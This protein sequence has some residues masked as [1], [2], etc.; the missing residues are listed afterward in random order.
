[1]LFFCLL[2]VSSSPDFES[3]ARTLEN[4][5]YVLPEGY[6]VKALN[7]L[8][9]GSVT[10][11]SPAA[12]DENAFTRT[13]VIPDGGYAALSEGARQSLPNPWSTAWTWRYPSARSGTI[14]VGR[15]PRLSDEDAVGD[16]YPDMA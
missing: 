3:I 8:V 16:R 12:A 1:M 4:I 15:T 10:R 14:I 13:G 11:F 7:P 9:S 2:N 5:P 6:K